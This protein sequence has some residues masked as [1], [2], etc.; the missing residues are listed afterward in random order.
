MYLFVYP[1]GKCHQ[2]ESLLD[3]E[4]DECLDNKRKTLR[5]F[6]YSRTKGFLELYAKDADGGIYWE[7]VDY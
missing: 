1:N 3:T 6:K 5:I 7:D 4:I 2:I